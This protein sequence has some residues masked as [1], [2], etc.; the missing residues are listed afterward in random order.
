MWTSVANEPPRLIIFHKSFSKASQLSV[1]TRVWFHA[2]FNW[3]QLGIEIE[4]NKL[5][6]ISWT[7]VTSRNQRDFVAFKS[8][9]I[10]HLISSLT[11]TLYKLI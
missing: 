7:T 3:C 10:I 4:K 11:Q 9:L 6:P 2:I 1:L 5:I 8:A